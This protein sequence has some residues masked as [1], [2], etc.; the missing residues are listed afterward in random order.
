MSNSWGDPRSRN[1]NLSPLWTSLLGILNRCSS[2]RNAS[3]C[4]TVSCV[5]R[6][7]EAS[8]QWET[9]A[10]GMSVEI[11][12]KTRCSCSVGGLAAG[13]A[14]VIMVWCALGKPWPQSLLNAYINLAEH[15]PPCKVNRG[16]V[17]HH[18]RPP[19]F[20]FKNLLFSIFLLS[21][22]YLFL[23]PLDPFGT[24]KKSKKITDLQITYRVYRR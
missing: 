10:P 24:E 22:N 15:C 2:E 20:I 1:P 18:T 6:G 12:L 21:F 13:R 19:I 11:D 23:K 16:C 8:L 3:V 7:G 14:L 5:C 4:Y 9:T 17:L